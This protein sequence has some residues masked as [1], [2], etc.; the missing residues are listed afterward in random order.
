[1]MIRELDGVECDLLDAILMAGF[2][3]GRWGLPH[4]WD[5]RHSRLRALMPRT[6]SP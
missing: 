2:V 5:A 3:T 4:R 6:R 1:M